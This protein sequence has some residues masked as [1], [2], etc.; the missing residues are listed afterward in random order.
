M[1][2][3]G[4]PEEKPRGSTP[5]FQG[6][7]ASKVLQSAMSMEVGDGDPCCS[8][9]TRVVDVLETTEASENG[10]RRIRAFPLPLPPRKVVESPLSSPS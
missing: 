10:H 4:S 3:T 9:D 1:I 7:R 6:Q 5:A 8:K 2:K